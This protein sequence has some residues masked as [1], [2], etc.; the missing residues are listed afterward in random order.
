MAVEVDG[1]DRRPPPPHVSSTGAGG[2]SLVHGASRKT[3]STT[4]VKLP[5]TVELG[6]GGATGQDTSPAAVPPS[7]FTPT[8]TR[9][10]FLTR[11]G[12]VWAGCLRDKARHCWTMFTKRKKGQSHFII[13]PFSIF[14]CY[15]SL[16]LMRPL[17]IPVAI[18]F[19]C[20]S[21]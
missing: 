12:T 17:A 16:M 2:G 21:N 18:L 6:C 14:S 19:M 20:L 10:H 15:F 4:T 3:T 9:L 11:C 8:P 1:V 5:V 7:P 13:P